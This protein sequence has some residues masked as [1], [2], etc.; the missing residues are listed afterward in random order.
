M[1]KWMDNPWFI[2]ILALLLAVLLYSSIQTGTGKKEIDVPGGAKTDTVQNIPVKVYYDIEN[3]VVTGIPDT[4][5][6]TLKGPITHVQTAKAMKNFEVYVDLRNAK[7]GR[8]KVKLKIDMLSDKIKAT[9]KPEEITVTVQERISKQFKIEAEFNQNIIEEGYSAG[10]PV[11]EPNKVK[12]T[13]AKDQID[14]IAYVKAVV[15][16]KNKLKETTTKEAQIQILDK[17]LNKLDAQVEPATVKVTIPIKENTKSVPINVIQKGTPPS[18]VKVESAVSD[19]KEAV[20]SGSEET[21]KNTDSVRVEVDV[22]KITDN[23]TLELP[24]IISNGITKVSPQMVKVT[25]T[26]NKQEEKTVSGVPIKIKGLSDQFKAEIDDPANEII[27]IIING[28]SAAIQALGPGDF[29]AYIDLSNLEEG[30]HEVN[31]HVEGP[32][33]IKAK[34]DKSTATITVTNNA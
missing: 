22:S 5:D 28:P 20:I 25:I 7:I 29:N 32:P 4:V 26:V 1:D 8:Q 27:N 11:V 13:G 23:T 18:G 21:L 33:N 3:L 15:E 9:I 16:E 2:K 10:K 6:V 31:I 34:P 14:R 19:T 12:I 30:S 24:V 17:D